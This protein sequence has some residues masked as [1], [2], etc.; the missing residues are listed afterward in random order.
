MVGI[1]PSTWDLL[2]PNWNFWTVVGVALIILGILG[3]VFISKAGVLLKTLGLGFNIPKYSLI[4]ILWGVFFVWGVSAWQ[5]FT[6]SEGGRLL[7][8]GAVAVVALAF[9]LFWKPKSQDKF[10]KLKLEL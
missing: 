3:I 5:D 4:A 7:F 10:E 2:A 1:F 8:W 6:H 9:M